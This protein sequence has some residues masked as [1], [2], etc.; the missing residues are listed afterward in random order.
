MLVKNEFTNKIIFSIIII[1]IEPKA[2]KFL[3]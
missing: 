2:Y 3:M 1:C